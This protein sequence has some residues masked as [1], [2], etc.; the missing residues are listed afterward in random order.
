LT[1]LPHG[2]AS[3]QPPLLYESAQRNS[4]K[5]HDELLKRSGGGE[6]PYLIHQQL[7]ELMTKAATVVRDNKTLDDAYAQVAELA[8]RANRCSLSDTGNWTNQNIVFTKALLDMFPLA[9]TIIRGARM[10]DEC[11]GAHYKPEFEFTGVDADDPGERRRQA[12]AWCDRFEEN[13]RR[14]LKTTLAVWKN[15]EPAISYEEVDTQSIPPRPRLYG[16]VGG[17]VIEE[18]WK[19]RQ[20]GAERMDSPSSLSEHRTPS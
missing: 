12:E 1:T 13:N 16:L 7:G 14:W 20:A 18:V 9:K 11:R 8:E 4:Q 3:D 6:N 5:H 19:Q 17:Q 2:T 15:H 10:R